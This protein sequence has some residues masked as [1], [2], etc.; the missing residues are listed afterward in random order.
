MTFLM[1]SLMN[2]NFL[3]HFTAVGVDNDTIIQQKT[4]TMKMQYHW[5]RCREA[6]GKFRFFWAPGA[7]NLA[8]YSTKNHYPFIMRPTGLPMR[9]NQNLY[10]HCKGV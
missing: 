5:L 1:T 4:K 8:Y 10:F 7:N 9:G 2:M 3:N 6:Q